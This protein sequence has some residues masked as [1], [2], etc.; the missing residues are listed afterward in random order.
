MFYEFL[1]TVSL[2]KETDVMQL[3]LFFW[4][5]EMD[6]L[7]LSFEVFYICKY[8]ENAKKFLTWVV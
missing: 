1:L 7:Q 2:K 8:W 4:S 6:V 3:P 5:R